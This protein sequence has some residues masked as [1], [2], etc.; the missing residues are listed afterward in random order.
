M[1]QFSLMILQDHA[2]ANHTFKPKNVQNGVAKWAESVGVPIGD[3]T[4]TASSTTTTNG[5]MK[6]TLKIA[7]PVLQDNIVGGVSRPIVVRT[8]YADVTFNF[9]ADSTHDE[10]DDILYYLRA[11][12]APDNTQIR[13]TLVDGEGIY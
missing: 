10:R 8:A 4:I 6:S 11:M 1:S 2:S 5:R 13:P 12:L 3:R 9:P 7:C